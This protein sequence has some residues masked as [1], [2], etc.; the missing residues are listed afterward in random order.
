MANKLT[1]TFNSLPDVDDYITLSAHRIS[2]DTIVDFTETFKVSRTTT[3]ECAIQANVNNQ[4]AAYK[5]AFK[6]DYETSLKA[7]VENNVVTITLL[8]GF[9]DI[10][11]CEISGSFATFTLNNQNISV[12]GLDSNGYLI[13]NEIW[14]NASLIGSG[15]QKYFVNITNQVTQ[16]S[17][18]N[19]RLYPRPEGGISVNL[20][21]MLKSFMREQP[22][23][24]QYNG[25]SQVITNNWTPFRVRIGCEYINS[26]N[27][28]SNVFINYDRNFFFGGYRTQKT[29]Q[30][31]S[32][33]QKLRMSD[34]LPIWSGYPTAE[35][36]VN[37]SFQIVKNTNLNTVTEKDFR[38]VRGCDPVYLKFKNSI[39]GYSYWLFEGWNDEQGNTGLGV[40]ESRQKVYD[41][42]SDVDFSL[43]TYS[44]VP[45]E[46]Y[47]LIQDLI[48][49]P[50]IYL[51]NPEE[52]I[53]DAWE[54]IRSV[55][56]R[57]TED[58]FSKV[59]ETKLRFQRILKYNPSVLWSK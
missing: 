59:Y 9:D 44:K 29:N 7:L 52:T 24:T 53:N 14:V 49:S 33:N 35:Y 1:I 18:G 34:R 10:T 54:R 5:S 50:E 26:D 16:E 37:S 4:A 48:I 51:Y 13:D 20:S 17:T 11:D 38:R 22:N 45:F 23:D 43:N 46:Y 8:S 31:V 25:L 56:N 21:P 3:G 36:T 19:L 39:G 15:A 58:P 28:T 12:T 41:L 30:N 40:N 32:V 57:T 6:T 55:S 47:G 27:F 2:D 42:G